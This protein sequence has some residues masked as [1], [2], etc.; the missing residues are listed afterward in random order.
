MYYSKSNVSLIDTKLPSQDSF[1][2]FS[3]RGHLSKKLKIVM[4][5]LLFSLPHIFF[6]CHQGLHHL[7]SPERDDQLCSSDHRA[8]L[9]VGNNESISRCKYNCFWCQGCLY[10]WQVKEFVLIIFHI[11]VPYFLNPHS[12]LSKSRMFVNVRCKKPQHL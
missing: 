4:L 10:S 6:S 3:E 8:N 7:V 12:T 9:G 1:F 11:P 2:F 5:F